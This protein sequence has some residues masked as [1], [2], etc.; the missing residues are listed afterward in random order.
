LP[1]RA[2]VDYPHIIRGPQCPENPRVPVFKVSLT[3]S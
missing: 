3:P 1:L 2:F